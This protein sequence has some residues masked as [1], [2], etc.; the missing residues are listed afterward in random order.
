MY[1]NVVFVI[2]RELFV[3]RSEFNSGYKLYLSFLLL[4]LLQKLQATGF[5]LNDQ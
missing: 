4:L 5:N 2:H 1:V 3:Q